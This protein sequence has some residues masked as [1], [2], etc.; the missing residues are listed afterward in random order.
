MVWK[1]I[2]GWGRVLGFGR[3]FWV[4]DGNLGFGGSNWGLVCTFGLGAVIWGLGVVIWGGGSNLGW[5]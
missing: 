2:L 1:V 5:R 4:G 3:Y